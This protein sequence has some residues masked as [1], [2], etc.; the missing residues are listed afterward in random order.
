M[1]LSHDNFNLAASDYLVFWLL[2]CACIIS[3]G[4][5]FLVP[6]TSFLGSLG[7]TPSFTMPSSIINPSI[8]F[9]SKTGH[10]RHYTSW[11]FK[12]PTCIPSAASF[13]QQLSVFQECRNGNLVW[14]SCS[15]LVAAGETN[16]AG[17]HISMPNNSTK[18]E[19]HQNWRAHKNGQ[20]KSCK[21]VLGK[22]AFV[23]T[24]SCNHNSQIWATQ[25]PC[26][27]EEKPT[28]LPAPWKKK[29]PTKLRTLLIL[30]WRLKVPP[31]TTSTTPTLTWSPVLLLRLPPRNR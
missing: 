7:Q 5:L 1:I 29:K 17:F 14:H 9:P 26:T 15:D 24:A 2:D 31:A 19:E 20:P 30:P 8:H 4:K 22:N 13:H 25:T 27:P 10:T 21:T 23:Q 16:L 18:L 12:A 28:K 3:L 6:G 11:C